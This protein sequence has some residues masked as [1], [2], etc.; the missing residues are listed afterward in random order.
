MVSRLGLFEAFGIEL[1]YM[2]VT[3]DSLDVF[4]ITDRLLHEVAGG[5]ESE[6][7][8]GDIT[9]SNE[10][11]LHVVELK[12]TAPARSLD[13]LAERFQENVARINGL[14]LRHGAKLMPTAVHP[15]MNPHEELQLWPHD[16]S[17]VYAAF[18]RVFDCTG[19]GWA[20]LQ[21]VHINLPFASDAEFGRLHAAIRLLL[22]LLPALAASSP[23]IDGRVSG[24][25]DTRLEVYRTNAKRVPSVSGLVIPEAVF[26]REDYEREI[27]AKMYGDIAPFDPNGILQ[28]EWLNS[29]GAIARFDRDAIEIRVLDIQECPAADV[30]ICQ[31]IVATLQ[32]L[33]CQQWSDAQHQESLATERLAAILTDVIRDADKTI[34]TDTDFLQAF[35]ISA[36]LTANELWHQLAAPLLQVPTETAAALSVILN[37]GPL[38]RRILDHVARHSP[39]NGFVETYRELCN[40]LATG[41]ML[42]SDEA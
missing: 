28:H 39:E 30:A 3:G 11:A 34:I 26:T 5:C 22:P 27:L 4:P 20:N 7:E 15:W 6:V 2:I 12:T 1:E 10:L 14:L 32:R 38:A 23:I 36:P 24:F 13:G 25:C 42:H 16:Y 31:L 33:V 29:R 41:K 17:E 18:N 35:G 21:S 8:L 9:W 19:H 40:C 37:Q